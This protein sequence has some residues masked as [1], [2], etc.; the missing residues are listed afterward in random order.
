MKMKSTLPSEKTYV[1]LAFKIAGNDLK[2]MM[3]I[4]TESFR[5]KND[6]IIWEEP[7]AGD[8]KAFRFIYDINFER[9]INY[10]IQ[11]VRDVGLVK[12]C[13]QD[14]FVDIRTNRKKLYEIKY[15]IKYHLL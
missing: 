13:I 8:E 9:P 7:K 14:L 5:V 1:D 10:G 6:Q 2:N 4:L 3:L 11:Y 15:P 12:D